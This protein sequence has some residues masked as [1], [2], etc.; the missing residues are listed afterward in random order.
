MDELVVEF[1]TESKEMLDTVENDL[2]ALENDPSQSR[3]LIP[4]IFRAVHTV[5]GTTGF[6][7]FSKLESVAHVAENLLSALRDGVIPLT[8]ERSTLLLRFVDSGRKLLQNIEQC[9]AEGDF[10]FSE[11]EERL[12]AAVSN[13]ADGGAASA[14]L[15]PA[16]APAVARPAEAAAVFAPETAVAPVPAQAPVSAPV[17][18]EEEADEAAAP[19]QRTDAGDGGGGARKGPQ[20]DGTVRVRVEI[21][22]KLMN[23]VGELVLARNELLELTTIHEAE[24]FQA[25]AQRLSLVTSELQEQV[26]NARMQPIKG[27]FNR[28]PRIVRDVAFKSQKLV[29]LGMEGEN[30]E[31]DKALLEA[32]A[33]PLTHL[34]RNSV[35]HGIETPET[36]AQLGK[37]LEGHLLLRANHEGGQV[38]VEVVDDGAGIDTDKIRRKAVEKGL[39][40]AERAAQLSNREALDI[41]FLAGFSTA[42]AVTNISGRGVGMDVVR[43]NIDRIGGSVEL[44]S[45]PGQGTNVR[46]NLPLT[47][48]IIPALIVISD[49]QRFAIPQA[50]VLELLCLGQGGSH[51]EIEYIHGTP[52]YRLR[53]KLLPLVHLNRLLGLDKSGEPAAAREVGATIVV[54]HANDS[55]FGLVVDDVLDT[56]EIV[57]KP[58][59]RQLKR[60]A[61]YSG[62]TI[63]GDGKVAL[64]LD[65]HALGRRGGLAAGAREH[66]FAEHAGAVVAE[67]DEKHAIVLFRGPDDARMAIPLGVV[68]RLEEIPAKSVQTIGGQ[69]YIQYRNRILPLA[70]INDVVVERRQAPRLADGANENKGPDLV[71]LVVL[72]DRTRMV[73]LVVDAI[74]DVSDESLAVRG[75]SSRGGVVF[76]ALVQDR[77]TEMLD[78]EI[79]LGFAG[80]RA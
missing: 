67:H 71:H 62:A 47:L 58:L 60:L 29:T 1:L 18:I 27:L 23:L 72:A 31:L 24:P 57:V 40:S 38:V 10:D 68:S 21:L 32:L 36:R 44:S 53:G 56:V 11:L 79:I 26:M 64:I 20:S 3:Q 39:L 15:I 2:I 37:P 41:I 42:K 28:I 9:G 63:M 76:T 33:D 54:L 59:S 74:L 52:V 12:T 75:P 45:T 14:A 80:A 16:T 48:A 73:G 17:T 34:V 65:V 49:E 19:E 25:T 61:I 51:S 55:K 70:R 46:I 66:L 35:D 30:T 7:G 69:S 6:F 43:S 22:D 4:A 8:A 13:R 78:T 5:K 50:S 77:V